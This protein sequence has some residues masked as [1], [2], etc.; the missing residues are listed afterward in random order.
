[1]ATPVPFNFTLPPVAGLWLYTPRRD[2]TAEDGWNLSFSDSPQQPDPNSQDTIGSG[3]AFFRTHTSDAQVA[4]TFD[5]TGMLLC[6][7]DNGAQYALTVDGSAQSSTAV[8]A[9]SDPACASTGATQ[10]YAIGNLAVGSHNAQLRVAASA[11]HEFQFYGGQITAAIATTG[12]QSIV[13]NKTIDDTDAGFSFQPPKGENAWDTTGGGKGLYNLTTTF[14]CQY[15]N[16]NLTT[17]SFTGAGGM[18][19]YGHAYRDTHDF[20]VTLQGGGKTDN[21][22]SD[23]STSGWNMQSQLAYFKG[24]LDPK[25]TYTMTLRNYNEDKPLCKTA[26]ANG[27]ACCVSLDALVLFTADGSSPTGSTTGLPMPTGG[28][29]GGGSKSNVGAIAGGIVAGLAAIALIGVLIFFLV[30]RRRNR[31]VEEHWDA[32][33]SQVSGNGHAPAP[34]F[35][36]VQPWQSDGGMAA[37]TGGT[38]PGSVATLTHSQSTYPADTVRIGKLAQMGL[39]AN[40]TPN[41]TVTG[42]SPPQSHVGPSE[43]S[44]SGVGGSQRPN[45]S[46]RLAPEDLNQVL[47]FVA[48]QMDSQQRPAPTHAEAAPP[49]YRD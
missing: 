29:P 31:D 17:Y 6:F 20:S 12:S 34:M 18:A 23:L 11:D 49:Q 15:G 40:A 3:H 4:I 22:K 32:S 9:A 44:A 36:V 30:R 7:T 8:D 39:V 47:A 41:G 28:G 43:D 33:T 13:T 10:M 16:D 21:L 14:D 19:V 45:Q 46:G 1:M 25:S 37:T 24:N 27:R 42:S 35:G 5:G 38:V 26:V 48:Q 2:D